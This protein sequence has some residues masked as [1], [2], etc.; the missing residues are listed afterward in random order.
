MKRNLK[1]FALIFSAIMILGFTI[2]SL[3]PPGG[4]PKVFYGNVYFN[5]SLL[6][7]GTYTVSALINNQV[8]GQAKVSS[9]S[10]SGLQVSTSDNFGTITFVVNSIQANETSTWYNDKSADWG[11]DVDLDLNLAQKPSTV[12]TCGNGV[13]DLGEECDGTNLAGR[14]SCGTG[15]TGNISCSS[16]CVIDYTNCTQVFSSGSSGGGS[17]GGGGGGGGGSSSSSSSS[18]GGSGGLINYLSTSNPSTGTS[19]SAATNT[20]AGTTSQSQGSS[21]PILLIIGI[22]IVI[23][24]IA[25]VFYNRKTRADKDY[26]RYGYKKR[27]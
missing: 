16:T 4:P 14:T 1:V 9:G 17:S 10:Y 8:V 7:S 19:A 6:A 26:K 24:V 11:Q 18:S 23:A 22:L 15:W 25:M 12:S 27:R 21:S 2:A 20:N 13:I 5:G 3:S